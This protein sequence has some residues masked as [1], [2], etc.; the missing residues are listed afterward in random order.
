MS[1]RIQESLT[2]LSLHL[3][4]R[5]PMSETLGMVCEQAR[6]VVAP[7]RYV[8]ITMPVG[9][10]LTS[11]AISDEL[12]N[13][14]DAAQYASADG[15]CVSA[16]RD[17]ETV[18]LRSTSA[19]ARYPE[20][21][22]V[23]YELGV[24]SVLSV[25]MSP[26]GDTVGALNLYGEREDAFATDID[27]GEEF[28][29]QAGVILANA[30]AYWEARSLGEHLTQAMAS[31]AEIEQA[32]GIIMATT[33]SSPD[34]AFDQLRQQSQHENVKVRELAAEIVRRAQRARRS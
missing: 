16:F 19:R 1:D 7:A 11:A 32:K 31:R 4:G 23:A 18:Y 34:E 33:G 17:G 13:E 25:P 30:Q 22:A 27:A 2:A 8:S 12:L 26:G 5:M 6:I 3:V 9:R 10:R 15:P 20:F 28:A 29:A 14:V 21:C 24:M